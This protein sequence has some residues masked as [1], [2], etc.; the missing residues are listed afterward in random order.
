[1]EVIQQE[2]LKLLTD[3]AMTT[4]A[5]R[6]RLNGQGYGLDVSQGE[7]AEALHYLFQRKRVAHNQKLHFGAPVHLI[8]HEARWTLAK[9]SRK[10]K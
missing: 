9:A 4:G 3:E 8:M 10:I 5:I 2:I 6:N 7:V 1:M